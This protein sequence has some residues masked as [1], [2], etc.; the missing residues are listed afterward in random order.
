MGCSLSGAPLLVVAWAGERGSTVRWIA[1]PGFTRS[2]DAAA[3]AWL[4]GRGVR[5]LRSEI[6]GTSP[7]DRLLAVGLAV[8]GEAEIWLLDAGTAPR[9]LASA[10]MLVMTLPLALRRRRPLLAV[11]AAAVAFAVLLAATDVS[12]DNDAYV[13]WFVML[14]VAYTAGAYTRGPA[15]AVGALC[16][17]AI[18]VVISLTDRDGFSVGGV[19]FFATFALPPYLAG[20]AMPAGA[21]G[22]PHSSSTPR[23]S[24]PSASAPRPRR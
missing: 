7:A 13:P 14:V 17:L 23:R 2:G 20:L 18:P 22:R 12:S 24:T 9:G 16:A 11:G 6:A 8:C 21:D 10:A 5:W 1:V 3:L 19:I 4:Y 15:I